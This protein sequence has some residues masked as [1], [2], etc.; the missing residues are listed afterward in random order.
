MQL[1]TYILQI[2]RMIVIMT[3]LTAQEVSEQFF[4]GKISYWSVLKM[5]KSGSLPCFK[6]GNRYLFDL[7]RL[8]EWK[9]ELNARPYWQQVI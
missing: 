2:E 3:L 7:D 6:R 9:T 1:K 5:A 8:T 4:G